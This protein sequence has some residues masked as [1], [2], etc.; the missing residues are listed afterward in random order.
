M[1]STITD[2]DYFTGPGF[3]NRLEK[4]ASCVTDQILENAEIT[5]TRVNTLLHAMALAGVPL[6]VSPKTGSLCSSGWRPPAVNSVTPGAAKKSKHLIGA[7]CDLYDPH[8]KLDEFCMRN[9]DLLERL[10][11]WLEHPESTQGWCH[12]QI[13]P[14]ESGNRVFRAK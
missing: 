1:T 12:V 8:E 13:F 7:A 11:L 5:V 9:E 6:V 2:A 3:E 10:C 14:P 4:Y